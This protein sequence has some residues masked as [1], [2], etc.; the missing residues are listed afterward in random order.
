M[1]STLAFATRIDLQPRRFLDMALSQVVGAAEKT[2]SCY[3][4]LSV[5]R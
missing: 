2:T 5:P 4:G 3:N 1:S